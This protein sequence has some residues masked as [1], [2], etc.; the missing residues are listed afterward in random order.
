VKTVATQ[1]FQVWLSA[2]MEA[3]GWSGPAIS[4]SGFVEPFDTWADMRH[5]IAREDWPRAPYALAYFC[6]VL[7]EASA[8]ER[9]P[10]RSHEQVRRNAIRFLNEDVAHI[11][12]QAA[13]RPGEF[14]WDLL[15]DPTEMERPWS[16]VR[17]E[18]RFDSQFWTANV[19][20]SDRYALSLPGT[21][22]YRISPLD[23]TY[24]N[25]TICG[26]WTACGFNAGCVEAAVMSG[27]LAAHAIAKSPALEDIVGYDHP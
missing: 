1:A 8:D 22:A 16:G 10:A 4:L 27:R 12:P 19:N 15:A 2:D 6:N 13:S 25:L 24:D 7:P 5:L 21:S 17:G 11:W 20:P 23:P 9:D 14:R 26:D 18:A 3:L